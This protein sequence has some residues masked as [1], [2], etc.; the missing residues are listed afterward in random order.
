MSE[1]RTQS[2]PDRLQTVATKLLRLVVKLALAI[3]AA[4][5]AV[6]LT[7]V[8][9][10]FVLV[11]TS[12]LDELSGSSNT[13]AYVAAALAFAVA[14][15]LIVLDRVRRIERVPH[16]RAIAAIVRYLGVRFSRYLW[17]LGRWAVCLYGG[18]R[19]GF[20]LA[21]LLNDESLSEEELREGVEISLTGDIDTVVGL[22][23]GI[24]IVAGA[25]VASRAVVPLAKGSWQLACATVRSPRACAGLAL[26]VLG[27]GVAWWALDQDLTAYQYAAPEMVFVTDAQLPSADRNRFP[28]PVMDVTV[29]VDPSPLGGCNPAVV[30][31][32]ASGLSRVAPAEGP[33]RWALAY[34]GPPGSVRVRS[35]YFDNEQRDASTVAVVKKRIETSDFEIDADSLRIRFAD[36]GRLQGSFE[37]GEQI[38]RTLEVVFEADWA[39]TRDAGSC[40]VRLPA[41]VGKLENAAEAA[42]DFLGAPS[43]RL[44]HWT[45]KAGSTELVP[46]PMLSTRDGDAVPAPDAHET[47]GHGPRWTCRMV[48]EGR[49][50]VAEEERSCGA[51]VVAEDPGL[52]DTKA[53]AIFIAGALASLGFQLIAEALR[54]RRRDSASAP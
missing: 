48:A 34:A 35:L 36:I 49:R 11:V 54:D 31:A 39:A 27:A 29:G 20:W 52:A 4:Y 16:Q 23:V 10:I 15:V 38:P 47:T 43:D 17:L 50:W 28:A 24:G 5:A 22:P 46:A 44:A 8:A 25:L 53:F 12:R 6:W 19:G 7:V 1:G 9:Q 41:L 42:A 30:T 26:T 13:Y 40:W 3:G 33:L 51:R 32:T 45:A 18:F 2:W 21:S 14:L 37:D